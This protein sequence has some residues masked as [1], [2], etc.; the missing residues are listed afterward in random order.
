LTKNHQKHKI[1]KSE[2]IR[3]TQKST[4]CRKWKNTKI[5]KMEKCKSEKMWSKFS[6]W[7]PPCHFRPKNRVPWYPQGLKKRRTRRLGFRKVSILAY[8]VTFWGFWGGVIFWHFF[9]HDLWFSVFTL[10]SLFHFL[11]FLH[12]HDFDDFHFFMILPLLLLRPYY[13][14]ETPFFVLQ[15]GVWY[16]VWWFSP[17]F[18]EE[19][20]F[21]FDV[22]IDEIQ[23]VGEIHR[24]GGK[25]YSRS[26]LSEPDNKDSGLITYQFNV[27]EI[28]R[29]AQI[30]TLVLPSLNRIDFC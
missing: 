8:L 1:I 30:Y 19:W 11:T 7:P 14:V 24:R 2:K 5:D 12:F 3:K 17:T 10:L 13:G 16:Y 25:W 9:C 29:V 18:L 15:G 4:K 23:D 22:G 27:G 28:H 26:P 21:R 6:V 20:F